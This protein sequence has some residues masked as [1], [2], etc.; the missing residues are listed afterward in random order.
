MRFKIVV[1]CMTLLIATA[2]AQSVRAA[3]KDVFDYKAERRPGGNEADRVYRRD[4]EASRSTVI[5]S[6]WPAAFTLPAR[7]MPTMR[8]PT[9]SSIRDHWPTDLSKA[10]AIIVQL[11]HS[12][13]AALDP[14]IK[15]AVDAER[16]SWRSTMASKSMPAS[17][18]RTFWIGW[19]AISNLFG[20]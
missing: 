4:R 18:G 14:H 7:S 15:A 3:D 11:N 9:P 17:K 20:P 1:A 16:D 13:Q 2:F 19:A 6:F 10:D 8:T 5:T 12:R